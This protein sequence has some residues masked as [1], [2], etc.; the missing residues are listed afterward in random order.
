[1]WY[2][3]S[4]FQILHKLTKFIFQLNSPRH[5]YYVVKE[6]IRTLLVISLHGPHFKKF[7][8]YYFHIYKVKELYSQTCHFLWLV[9]FYF[10][11]LNI[12]VPD[13]SFYWE[14]IPFY[15]L[16]KPISINSNV[17]STESGNQAHTRRHTNKNTCF[18]SI[19][20]GLC[21]YWRL[22]SSDVLQVL[23]IQ[24]SKQLLVTCSIFIALKLSIHISLLA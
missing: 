4:S 21:A 3:Y 17:R 5:A 2:R 9:C 20:D 6:L 19:K 23:F 18:H 16:R 13:I 12:F 24:A 8:K 11:C 22:W 1:M 10:R 7:L 14:L 15:T